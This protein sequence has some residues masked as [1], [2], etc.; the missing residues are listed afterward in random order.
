MTSYYKYRIDLILADKKIELS[1]SFR[2]HIIKHID[3]FYLVIEDERNMYINIANKILVQ[4][5]YSYNWV[6]RE[7]MAFLWML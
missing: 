2:I 3:L 7:P 6:N 1:V 4:F 5:D